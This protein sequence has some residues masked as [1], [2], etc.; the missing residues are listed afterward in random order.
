MMNIKEI[1]KLELFAY[2]AD[3]NTFTSL[4]GLRFKWVLEQTSQIIESVPLSHAQLYLPLK[5]R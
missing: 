3:E 2:D 1:Q 4:E 5:T